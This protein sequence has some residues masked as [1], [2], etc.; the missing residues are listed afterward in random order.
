MREPRRQLRPAPPDCASVCL[1]RQQC[2][3]LPATSTI[4]CCPPA[5]LLLLPAELPCAHVRSQCIS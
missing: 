1:Q 5:T 4:D 3:L 2:R